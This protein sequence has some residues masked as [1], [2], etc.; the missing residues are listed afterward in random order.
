MMGWLFGF[1]GL[2][3]V[4]SANL[5]AAQKEINA[6]LIA[7][8]FEPIKEDGILGPATCGAA[9]FT[10]HPVLT[11][12]TCTKFAEP[13]VSAAGPAIP[14]PGPNQPIGPA[15]VAPVI[16]PVTPPPSSGFL[17]M[18]SK[19]ILIGAG[20]VAGGI[21]LVYFLKQRSQAQPA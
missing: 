21:V 4:S 18:D 1:N 8:G 11:Q 6:V 12:L 10:S 15:P 3:A 9:R 14:P 7:R 20:V 19:T 5:R 2:G 13:K 17:G 16:G